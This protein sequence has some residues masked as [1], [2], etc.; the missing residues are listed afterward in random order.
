MEISKI[1][2]GQKKFFRSQRTFDVNYRILMLRKFRQVIIDYEEEIPDW[3]ISMPR[4]L[5]CKNLTE[6]F[7]LCRRGIILLCCVWNQWWEQLQQ[8]IVAC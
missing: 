1:V 7:L 4:V 8:G 6:V 3:Q 5:R 2:E